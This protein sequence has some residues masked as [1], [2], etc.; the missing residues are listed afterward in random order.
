MLELLKRSVFI[1]EFTFNFC[2]NIV[3]TGIIS[4]NTMQKMENNLDSIQHC[5][6]MMVKILNVLRSKLEASS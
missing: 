6:T 5:D 4:A 3:Q 1:H 2:S